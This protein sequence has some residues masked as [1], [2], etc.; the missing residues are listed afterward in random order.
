MKPCSRSFPIIL[1]AL[2]V[3]TL[4]LASAASAD[5]FAHCTSKRGYQREAVREIVHAWFD[6]VARPESLIDLIQAEQGVASCSGA[7]A[8]A[9]RL[10]AT[11]LPRGLAP[12]QLGGV[13]LANEL[14][15]SG[16]LPEPQQGLAGEFF[17]LSTRS[18]ER[19]DSRDDGSGE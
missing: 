13:L 1:A 10:H 11:R 8:R 14:E 4:A 7:G 2:A 9:P 16:L 18:V 19:Y 12:D 3:A 15:W 6:G 5:A 17:R